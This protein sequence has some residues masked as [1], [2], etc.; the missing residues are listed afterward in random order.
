MRKLRFITRNNPFSKHFRTPEWNRSRNYKKVREAK[1]IIMNYKKMGNAKRHK[2]FTLA[3]K[4][5]NSLPPRWKIKEA[6]Q[7]IKS[8]LG[9]PC[10][11]P[12]Q[13]HVPNTLVYGMQGMTFDT[14]PKDVRHE[15][16]PVSFGSYPEKDGDCFVYT[17]GSKYRRNKIT[18]S[19]ERVI[20][21]SY[22][23]K[24]ERKAL[25]KKR[26]AELKAA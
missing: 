12:R 21:K 17:D 8:M 9:N 15:N 23:N 14:S 16:A 5:K 18:G 4:I 25:K 26:V 6:F 24:A 7:I 20:P 2:K 19:F 1:K 11:N 10:Y 22:T 3:V 13:D